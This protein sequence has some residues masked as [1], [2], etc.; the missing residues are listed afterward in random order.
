MEEKD[1][2]TLGQILKKWREKSNLTQDDLAKKIN[3]TRQAVS[4]WETNRALPDKEILLELHK[5]YGENFGNEIS[6][7]KITSKDIAIYNKKAKRKAKR[8]LI[9]TTIIFICLFSFLMLS[10]FYRNQISLYEGTIISDNFA[11]ENCILLDTKIKRFFKL[12]N[13][14]IIS[15]NIPEDTK[16]KINLYFHN[17]KQERTILNSE[18]NT[19]ITINEDYNYNE[20]FPN[21]INVNE[22]YIDII[23]Y[24]EG[25]QQ[26]E[27]LP[28]N[29][30]KVFDNNKWFYFTQPI[31]FDNK[32][33]KKEQENSNNK[34]N[35]TNRL[36]ELKYQY[37]EKSDNWSK[38]NEDK[39]I[40]AY[41][42]NTEK[43]FYT[44]ENNKKRITIEYDATW[45]YITYYEYSK[46]T[47][48]EKESWNYYIED[49]KISCTTGKC[50]NHEF[51]LELIFTEYE[52]I[53]KQ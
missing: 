40:W 16:L 38:E 22:I 42:I 43:L 8:L 37:D 9:I 32:K 1:K 44:F 49:N 48:R 53:K 34:Q 11:L 25:K 23:Y 39:S 27:T 51:Y 21:K 50:T 46:K 45:K 5:I 28:L 33:Q 47:E 52:K 3:V 13:I 30:T 35:I 15:K 12:G 4:N 24:D 31:S 20:Y 2:E 26:I 6:L 36:K 7:D 14:K 17:G 18:Y 19:T 29:F 41:D 10:L